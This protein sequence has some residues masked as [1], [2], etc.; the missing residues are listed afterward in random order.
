MKKMWNCTG[1]ENSC[2]RKR[3]FRIMKLSLFFVTVLTFQLS[4][5]TGWSQ[6]ETLN[7]KTENSSITEV[8]HSIEAQTGLSFF[9]QNEQ[10]KS[11]APISVEAEGETVTEVL[12]GIFAN[13]HLDFRIVDKHVVIFPAGKEKSG[14]PLSQQDELPVRGKVVDSDGNPV[15]GVTVQIKGTQTGTITDMDGNYSLQVPDD[16][17]TLIF[18]FIGMQTRQ[19]MLEGQ[20]EVDV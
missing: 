10:L 12:T 6:N 11:V 17:A 18:S 19:V 15:P 9:Y 4:A 5:V 1:D 16:A 2:V 7:L 14:L 8:I 3:I 13:T 20:T